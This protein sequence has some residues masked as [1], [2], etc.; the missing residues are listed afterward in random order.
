MALEIGLFQLCKVK[1]YLKG[2]AFLPK[3]PLEDYLVL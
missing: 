1:N 3:F 2:K